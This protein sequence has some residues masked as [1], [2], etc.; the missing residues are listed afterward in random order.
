MPVWAAGQSPLP[1][2]V[3]ASQVISVTRAREEDLFIESTFMRYG[4]SP[5]GLVGRTLQPSTVKRWALSLHLCA[6]LRKN[7][8]SLSDPD[9]QTTVTTHKEEGPSRIQTDAIDREKIR[10]KLTTC[11]DPL[12]SDS[13]HAGVLVNIVTGRM[14]SPT[15]NSGYRLTSAPELRVLPPRVKLSS[16][17]C[18]E[19]ISKLPCGE[20]HYYQIHLHSIPYSTA[21]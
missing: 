9:E 11:I 6:Q 12:N 2:A 17:M 16:N 4:H 14:A 10:D 8:M 21:G 18:S 1:L 7:V 19:L 15:V 13:H 5:G 3:L 20:V